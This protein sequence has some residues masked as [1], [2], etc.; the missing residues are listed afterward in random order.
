MTRC[1]PQAGACLAQTLVEIRKFIVH[2]N[3]C[4]NRLWQVAKTLP[5]ISER[6]NKT[7]K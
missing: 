6:P 1:L 4:E 2:P 5:A 3:L 7:T